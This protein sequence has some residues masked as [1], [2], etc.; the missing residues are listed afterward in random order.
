MKKATRNW[1]SPPEAMDQ[2]L[3]DWPD[4][5]SAQVEENEHVAPINTEHPIP[6]VSLSKAER[7][8]LKRAQAKENLYL[9]EIAEEKQAMTWAGKD[10]TW[11]KVARNANGTLVV[12]CDHCR[13]DLTP[14]VASV[15]LHHSGDLHQVNHL[16]ANRYGLIGGFRNLLGI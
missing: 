12:R 16:G 11:I 15:R 9:K 4:Q 3:N 5:S 7:K 8:K 6:P 2:V 10:P 1:I 14:S 13:V